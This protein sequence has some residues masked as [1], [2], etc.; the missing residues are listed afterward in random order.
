MGLRELA[1]VGS[2]HAFVVV[3]MHHQQRTW[4]EAAGSIHGPKATELACP[5]VEA[6]WKS[7]STYRTDL[8]GVFEQASWLCGPIIEVGTR[9]QQRRTSYARVV[10]GNAGRDGAARVGA[11]QPDTRWLS[12]VN[13]VIDGCPQI[14]DPALQRE[15]ALAR[16]AAVKGERHRHPAELARHSIDQLRKCPAALTRVEGTDRKAV[17]QY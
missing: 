6:G 1:S 9:A 3:T 16:A 15:V 12:L 17:A 13:Q 4:R 8:A 5:L 7:R 2:G 14:V 11:D 10:S